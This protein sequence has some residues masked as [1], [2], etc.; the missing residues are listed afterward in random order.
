MNKKLLTG[1]LISLALLVFCIPM[2]FAST[3]QVILGVKAVENYYNNPP[4]DDG[5][6]PYLYTFNGTDYVMQND[7]ISV[8]RNLANEY[9]DYL[10]LNDS[11]V[12]TDGKLKLQLKEIPM[13]TSK[14]DY[15]GVYVVN[16][17]DG[18]K[19]GVDEKGQAH[20]YANP[21]APSTAT[22]NGVSVLDQVS[23]DDK[24]GVKL[25]DQEAITLEF[26]AMD[27]SQGGKL[28]LKVDGF[29]RDASLTGTVVIKVPAIEI[30]TEENG[31]WVT[32]SKFYPK[33]YAASGVFDLKPYVDGNNIKVR[34]LSDS[35]RADV[36]HLIDY[37][38]FDNTAD[39]CT[40]MALTMTKALKNDSQ[41]VVSLLN[42]PD[43]SYLDLNAETDYVNLEFDSINN[44]GVNDYFFVSKGYY[45]P[46]RNTFYVAVK[47]DAGQWVDRY[48]DSTSWYTTGADVTKEVDLTGFQNA[49]YFPGT[50]GTYQVRISNS[51]DIYDNRYAYIDYAYLKVN[52]Q[53]YSMTG[54]VD[55]ASGED[56]LAQLQSADEVKW[57]ALNKGV[58][59]TFTKIPVTGVT[60]NK[61][62]TTIN[63]GASETLTTTVLPANA[64]D[65]TL[66]WS[67]SNT[68]VAI[69]NQNGLVTAVSAGTARIT[70]ASP[71]GPSAG[72][73][74][75][76]RAPVTGVTLNK[77]ATTINRGAQEILIAT[78]LPADADNKSLTWSSS[79]TAVAVVDQFG[80]VTAVSAGSA[81]ITAT[82]PEGPTAGCDVIIS[83]PVTGVT[84]NKATTSLNTGS[85]ETLTATVDPA[86]ASDK[87]LTWS[88]SNTAVATVDQNGTITGVSA[89]TARITATSVNGKSAFC[90]V[91]V[92]DAAPSGQAILG[93]KAVE[94][95]YNNAPAD[96][97]CPYLYTFNGSEY[98][99]ENDIFSVGRMPVN[100]Y[101]DY[102]FLNNSVPEIDGK[103]KLRV[104]EIPKETSK[105]DYL[106]LS[107]INH[108][109]GTKA[110]VDEKGQAHT[111]SNP[112]APSTA[113]LNGTNVLSDISTD[114]K[115]GVNL[116][117]QE[118]ITLE[119]P[120][121]DLSQGAKLIL[122]AD[123]FER[124]ETRPATIT[125]KVPAIDIQTEENGQWVTRGKFYPKMLAANG[126]FDLKPYLDEDNI[127]VRLL[128]LSCR[129][130]VSHLV[131]Y[132]AFDNTADN[133]TQTA[134]TLTKALKNDTED[135]TGLVNSIDS[136]YLNFTAET[137]FVSLEY[138]SIKN[139]GLNDYVFVSRGSYTPTLNTFYVATK[140][141]A[142][143]WVDRYTD[144]TT[145]FTAG[146]DVTKEIDMSGY[147]NGP[148]F[149][150]A[151]GTYQV[152]ISNS[153]GT[154]DNLWAYLDYAYLK[155]NGQPYAL[156]SAVDTVSGQA[157]GLQI[158]S[159][160]EVKWDILN[161]GVILTFGVPVPVTGVSLNKTTTTISQG[162]QETLTA[163]LL[164]AAAAYN[165][166]T[167]SS[168]NT[169]VATVSQSGSITA[170][171]VGTVRI[172]ATSADGPSA[173]CDV[174]VADR[175]PPVISLLTPAPNTTITDNMP[176]ISAKLTDTNGI[177]PT[178]VTLTL[179]G[180]A[181][182]SFNPA[183]GVVS[184]QPSSFLADGLH[185]VAVTGFDI[186]DNP[187]SISWSFTLR[188]TPPQISN[189]LPPNLMGT[190]TLRPT[191][192]ANA[193][194]SAGID[195]TRL[196]ITVDGTALNVSFTP[197][198]PG[199]VVSG[200]VY[201]VPA[202]N[203][204]TAMH[205]AVV[206]VFDR[207]GNSTQ[208]TWQFGVNTFTDMT[209]DYS[210]CAGCHTNA[211]ER[212]L[213]IAGNC[214]SCHAIG[215]LW[216]HGDYPCYDCHGGHSGPPPV[217][218]YACTSCHG[219]NI[220]GHNGATHNYAGMAQDCTQC[221][222][223]N[224]TFEHN[225]YVEGSG[226]SHNCGTCH[227]ST[228][229]AVQT[230][231]SSSNTACSACH[232]SQLDHE[233]V[234]NTTVDN[235]CKTCHA[236]NLKT[237][238]MTNRPELGLTCNTCH[239]SSNPAVTGAIAA[240][241]TNCGACHNVE[242]GHTA[243]HLD[244]IDTSC[245]SCHTPNLVTDHI[246][247][248]SAKGLTCQS[249]HNKNVLPETGSGDAPD[250][251]CARCHSAA[252]NLY[253]AG[254]A[255]ADIPL[256]AGLKWSVPFESKI[257][258]GETWMPV[259]YEASG[260]LLISE[261]ST[262]I[263]G[264]VVRDYYNAELTSGGWTLASA[265]PGDDSNFYDMTFTSGQR[266]VRISFYGGEDHNDSPLVSS[267]YRLEILYK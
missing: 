167:W 196:S 143:Q 221:H 187:A 156:Y 257:F 139:E 210:N 159:P 62:T 209:A 211:D 174:T 81:H 123:G 5:S 146:A 16:H 70:A 44:P 163:T 21:V 214:D 43:N 141:G 232:G 92:N 191:V 254:K 252:H 116:F 208:Q 235:S 259:E 148:S 99:L 28:V 246:T 122:K 219:A 32:R 49:S 239:S 48:T 97:S 66:T 199:S 136:S 90:D 6:C 184:Y 7:I 218:W 202:S 3:P 256:Y 50:D 61:T 15:L 250:M 115:Q 83:V 201:G 193:S 265:L 216:D 74:V 95:Y 244:S 113:T 76:V 2:L 212:H 234:H 98:V 241:D 173:F 14:L 94:Y 192:S 249:C 169:G 118:A 189:V 18:T 4:V 236:A 59:L 41:D 205:T 213:P 165:K 100:E 215:V 24:Q 226:N 248:R 36:S 23:T 182:G 147:T 1:I 145:W 231:I 135:V 101:T 137:D 30:Q 42:S 69:V 84:L 238:H 96:D 138:D 253:I 119:F 203:L 222:Q 181:V 144:S 40:Q 67:S 124:D 158:Q 126:V 233:A 13:E 22:S 198:Q 47:D 71:D 37:V 154:Y 52:G 155:I 72:C 188:D 33:E 80:V 57:D 194:D 89:G 245:Q 56:V 142:D 153:I 53:M 58:I 20:T 177:D 262:A 29:E 88:S 151:D 247:D 9:T 120:A 63:K 264:K 227:G 31:Q 39:N 10:F 267:G 109:V 64:G 65:K 125:I 157:A 240:H 79:N 55:A 111:Y 134:L 170:V 229:P 178:K 46:T 75:T 104:N 73:D 114:N 168:S 78:V 149:P 261:R 266:K 195:I 128:S 204:S 68:A 82:S 117:D 38:A 107:V 228:D 180:S 127:K 186:Y 17:P 206:T 26:P 77:T 162:A 185:N 160:D 110:G 150:A 179:D 27:L 25:Y 87:A 217:S 54:A 164:P 86:D 106:G 133:C 103:I 263:T 121:M 132:V 140:D 102:L 45:T 260:K 129:A 112:I 258:A 19:A 85:Q 34:L 166:L 225:V 230:A 35:C 251:Q 91:T 108:P 172:T 131:D 207:K 93:V 190:R 171:S 152:R 105:M 197:D 200:K 223:A 130:D 175:T 220:A 161:R 51:I 183:T 242:S 255:P 12:V 60:L 11:M 8:A 176:L 237:E 224:L 243:M